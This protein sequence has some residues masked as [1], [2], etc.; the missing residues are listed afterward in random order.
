[1]RDN[2]LRIDLVK[3]FR[4]II[5]QLAD[6]EDSDLLRRWLDQQHGRP[7]IVEINLES[8]RPEPGSE[9]FCPRC[10][11]ETVE[12]KGNRAYCHTCGLSW[13]VEG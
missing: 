8:V 5:D 3:L 6:S 2:R 4:Q 1:M 7:R 12:T 9:P 13:K 10:G 11:Y